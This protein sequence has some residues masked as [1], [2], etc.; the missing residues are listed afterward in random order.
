MRLSVRLL[1]CWAISMGSIALAGCGRLEFANHSSAPDAA[2][3]ASGSD[4]GDAG[5][6]DLAAQF[7]TP[8]LMT[9]LSDPTVADGT[10]RLMP[11]ELTG[12]FWSYR[13]RTDADLYYVTRPDR[14]A[15]FTV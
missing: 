6:C 9:D 14:N 12:Y 5:S 8:V 3:D 1:S 4:G 10:L 7:G 15:T 13:G 2:S 11:D